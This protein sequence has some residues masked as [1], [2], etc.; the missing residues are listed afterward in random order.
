MNVLVPYYHVFFRHNQKFARIF[1]ST[2]QN[3]FSRGQNLFALRVWVVQIKE[4]RIWEIFFRLR[5]NPGKNSYRLSQIS[6]IKLS[7]YT[8]VYILSRW[9]FDE[10]IN[11]QTL[12]LFSTAC[13]RIYFTL[14]LILRTQKSRQQYQFYYF[15]S[16]GLLK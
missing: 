11:L 3:G 5:L 8:F 4:I 1:I 10:P 2:P 16:C 15:V 14:E 9:Y 7:L 12:R 6:I 13:N